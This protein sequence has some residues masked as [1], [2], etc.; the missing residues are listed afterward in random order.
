MNYPDKNLFIHLKQ[1]LKIGTFSDK[2]F[3]EKEL[4]VTRDEENIEGKTLEK[5]L[6]LNG[7]D[8]NQ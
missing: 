7:P 1:Q 4:Y 6:L 8:K 3:G 2:Y 5:Y